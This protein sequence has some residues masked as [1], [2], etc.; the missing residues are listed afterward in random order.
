MATEILK[1]YEGSCLFQIT[2]TPPH[3]LPIP[4]H[5]YLNYADLKKI[6]FNFS[7]AKVNS[8]VADNEKDSEL[9]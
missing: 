8:L 7:L 6:T 2:N 4:K 9:F 1:H 3:T 5:N